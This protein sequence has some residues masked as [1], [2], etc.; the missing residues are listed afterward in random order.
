MCGKHWRLTFEIRS[1]RLVIRYI[2]KRLQADMLDHELLA[3]EEF[4][5]EAFEQP[6]FDLM[7]CAAE[8]SKLDGGEV[9]GHSK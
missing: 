1:K 8:I 2:H 5:G 3:T 4:R 7:A 6:L 9:G